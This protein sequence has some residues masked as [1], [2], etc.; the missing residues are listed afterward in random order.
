MIHRELTVAEDSDAL[1]LPVEAIEFVH[2]RDRL[3]RPT[4]LFQGGRNF[5]A[6][7]FDVLWM[8][9]EV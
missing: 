6:D 1:G 7:G 5:L 8:S 2:L 4:V 3:A 9:D